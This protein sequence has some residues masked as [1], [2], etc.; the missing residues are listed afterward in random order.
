MN[1]QGVSTQ[2]SSC[3]SKKDRKIADWEYA[4]LERYL[5]VLLDMTETIPSVR[6]HIV[7]AQIALEKVE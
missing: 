6:E 4:R 5:D 2:E 1:F 3:M 7:R